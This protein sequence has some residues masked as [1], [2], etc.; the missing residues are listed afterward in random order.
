MSVPQ[1][2]RARDDLLCFRPARLKATEFGDGVLGAG[3]AEID[4]APPSA[5]S[6]R[7]RAVINRGDLGYALPRDLID[8]SEATSS[9]HEH[10]MAWRPKP[11]NLVVAPDITSAF[12]FVLMSS[13]RPA[14][15]V[16]VPRP[17]YPKLRRVA[18]ELGFEVLEYAVHR[19]PDGHAYALDEIEEHLRGRRRGLV[20]LLHPHNPT[21]HL[22]QVAEMEAIGRIVERH[23]ALVFSDEVH[24]PLWLEDEPHVPYASSSS[25]A[26]QHTVTALSSSK[27]WG[28][29]GARVTQLVLPDGATGIWARESSLLSFLEGSVSAL[30]VQAAIAAYE[31]GDPW[32]AALRSRLR[33]NRDLITSFA[34]G[35]VISDY[36]PPGSSFLAW[37]SLTKDTTPETTAQFLQRRARLGVLGAEEFG[38]SC[39]TWF[40]LNF[41]STPE[42]IERCLSLIA[43]AATIN[44]DA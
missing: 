11:E 44:E 28:L 35:A 25:A 16:L 30:G 12:A 7:L 37:M 38:S 39:T 31:H 4:F 1:P 24:A 43:Y 3:S 41:G 14:G 2:G 21:G 26:R 10:H 20:V 5:I 36:V 29:S 19:T 17:G 9:W 6:Q 15:P 33:E 40:R 18:S 23:G 22:A 13:A 27:A 8:L 42:V 34:A 32:L